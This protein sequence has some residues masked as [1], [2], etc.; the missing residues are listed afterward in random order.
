MSAPAAE[1]FG[2]QAEIS[3]LLD[4]I[5]NTVRRPGHFCTR[6]DRGETDIGRS[7]CS[8]PLPVLLEQGD[9]PP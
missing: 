7:C 8:Y 5:I 9:L 4:L 1:T 2:F 6:A 3:Q